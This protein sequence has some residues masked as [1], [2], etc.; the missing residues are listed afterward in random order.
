MSTE[1]IYPVLEDLTE[2]EFNHKIS[3]GRIR[4]MRDKQ[5]QLEEKLKHYKKLS[6]RWTIAKNVSEGTGVGLTVICGVLAVVASS[7]VIGIPLLLIFSTSSGTLATLITTI[8]NKAFINKHRKAL[9]D[10]YTRTKETHD[11]LFLYFQ[12]CIE[13]KIITL[14]EIEQFERL[15]QTPPAPSA[16]PAPLPQD[17][18]DQLT[19]LITQRK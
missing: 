15:T 18:L 11:K 2:D 5:R 4:F 12:K 9:K 16:P 3:E 8:T 7:G 17:F 10:K 1:R 6:K 13:D 14:E 19:T